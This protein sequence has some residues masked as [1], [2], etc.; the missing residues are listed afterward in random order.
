MIRRASTFLLIAVA[1]VSV[2]SVVSQAQSQALLTRHTRD[3]VIHGE[4]QSLGR[5]PA[6]ET[7]HLDVMLALRHQP[8][9]ENFLQELYDPSSSSYRHFLTV[10]EFTARFG[11]SQEEYDQV[12]RFAKQNGF[13]IVGDEARNRMVISMKGTVANIEK[14][15]HVQL[16]VY[17]H[18]REDRTFYAPD[19]EPSVDL[20]F[21]LWHVDGLENFSIPRPAFTRTNGQA[22]SNATVGSGP[23]A[24]FLGSD[25]RAAYYGTGSLNGTG[26]T[27]G[28]FE[29]EGT[30]L[31]DLNT[32]YANVHQT[33]NVPITLFSVG[34][35][36]TSCTE[37]GCDDT[38]QTL[39]MTQAL[40]MAPNL[41]SLVMYIGNSETP[42]FN[43]MATASPLNAQLSCS[44]YWNPADPKTLDPIF[45][46]FAAQGQNLFDAAGDDHDWQES[47]SIWPADDAYL[48]SVG[49]TDLETQS[50]GGPW[51][52]ETAW[53]DGGGGV[54]PNNIPI[55]SWQVATAAGCAKCSQ[56]LRNG[57]D[58]SA[59]SNFTFYVC[60][61][62]A[63][64]TENEYGGTSFAA[65]MWAGYLALAN[66]QGEA[67]GNPPLGFV[68][69]AIY[70]IG[71][72]GSYTT[73]F[74]DITSGSNGYP[75]TT[76]YDLAT[77]WGSPNG[78]NLIN[79]LT[80]PAGPSFTLT[81]NPSSLT[82]QQGT[83]GTSTITVV[84]A[85][86][87]NGSVTLSA[88]NLPNGVTAAF[89]PNP[90][91][92]TSTLTLTA[93]AGAATGTST[94]TING[95]SGSL[96]GQTNIQLTVTASG[97]IVSLNPTSLAW[98]KVGVGKTGGAKTVTVTNTGGSTLNITSIATSGDFAL[99]A[100][101][102]KTKCGSTLAV[103]ASC[104]VKVSFT[105]T[106]TGLRTGNLSFTDNA[107]GSPQNVALSGT[108]K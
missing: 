83:Q 82:V 10:E 47:G 86:G 45:Q 30:D 70:A 63:P 33:L 2:V 57:P 3:A 97:P 1:F 77:G 19:R 59:N 39:D 44:W 12:I 90:T 7:L 14:A 35:A 23:G 52:S 104:I 43:A 80:Q 87:F 32:Y 49:G 98:G 18:P 20:P 108:G 17:Q 107:P 92:T 71:L 106:Q 42:I 26:Q 105:P 76:G 50:A 74:H 46:E 9:L 88:S 41:A 93:A 22:K 51:K 6:S 11:P 72:S 78:P 37:P 89:N 53:S 15:F 56:T 60:A 40:G 85:D 79:A 68:N 84:P 62:Q 65:P 102:S 75:A 69:P 27:L 38:E 48:V 101:S 55:P 58:V 61:D 31:A 13:Q 103:N 81:A 8:E 66:Q 91:S 95:V 64:C 28:L 21:Q 5:L 34:G 73:D 96:T 25:M 24:S 4:A 100:F 99:K 36:K 94:I 67:S 29:L 16:G 54:S